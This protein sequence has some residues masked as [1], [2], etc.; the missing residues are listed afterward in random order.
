M[1]EI[2]SSKTL[3]S[4]MNDAY[5]RDAVFTGLVQPVEAFCKLILWKQ[6]GGKT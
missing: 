5:M 1:L 6:E 2:K 3:G 4:E